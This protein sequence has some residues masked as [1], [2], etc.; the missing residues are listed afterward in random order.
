[1]NKKIFSAADILLPEKGFE[2]WAVIACDQYTSRPDY[3]EKL[4]DEIGSAPSALRIILPEVY[5]KDEPE[6]RIGKINAEMKKYLDENIF[7]EYKDAMI[8]VERTLPDGKVRYGIVGKIDL[9]EYDFSPDSKTPVRATEGTVLDRL[10]PRVKIRKDAPLELPHIMILIDDKNKTVIEPLKT[11][12]LE[13][14]YDFKLSANGGSI[15]GYL[16]P[17]EAQERVANAI[18]ALADGKDE[19]LLFAM[20]DGNHSLATAKKCREL[21][22]TELNRYALVEIVNIHDPA[23]EFEPIYRAVFNVDPEDLV[24]YIK[25]NLPEN[26]KK[27]VELFYGD[28]REKLSFDGLGADVLQKLIDAYLPEHPGSEVDYIHGVEDTIRLA[29]EPGTVGLVFDGLEKDELFPYVEANGP[30]PRKTFSMG[31]ADSKRYYVE[32]RKIK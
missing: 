30:L 8:F 7:T 2:K 13:K 31:E 17:K 16:V 29:A 9:D 1:M 12:T 21:A 18:D 26:G 23:L 24:G 11:E 10:P 25:K 4:S 3:W 27:T 20:G 28:K 6:K 5:L 32:A 15:K 14:L 19:P 22:P